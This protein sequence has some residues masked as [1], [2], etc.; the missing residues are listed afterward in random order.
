MEEKIKEFR[1]AASRGNAVRQLV[2]SENWTE[3]VQPILDEKVDRLRSEAFKKE[4]IKDHEAY[5]AHAAKYHAFIELVAI[6]NATIEQG[7][8]AEAAL[9]EIDGN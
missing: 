1:Q 2:E 9:K 6:F 7:L 8:E 3:Y 4:F 5:I